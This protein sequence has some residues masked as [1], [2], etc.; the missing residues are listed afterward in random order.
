MQSSHKWRQKARK[1]ETSARGIERVDQGLASSLALVAQIRAPGAKTS[2]GASGFTLA[3]EVEWMTSEKIR[4]PV[5]DHLLTPQN[6]ALA[7]V[8]Y[9]PVQV[10]P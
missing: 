7:I 6:C 1:C 4:D 9:Q 5:T 3:I 10:N 2:H 8:D